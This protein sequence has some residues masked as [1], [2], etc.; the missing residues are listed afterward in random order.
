MFT[1]GAEIGPVGPAAQGGPDT[2]GAS[3]GERDYVKWSYNFSWFNFFNNLFSG[4]CVTPKFVEVLRSLVQE[5]T[6]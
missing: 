2:K 1:S 6:R 3:N 5:M 4:S